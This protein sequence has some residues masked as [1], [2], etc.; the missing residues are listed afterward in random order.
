MDSP[1]P[2]TRLPRGAI[3]IAAEEAEKQ[4]DEL[5]HHQDVDGEGARAATKKPR[6]TEPTPMAKYALATGLLLRC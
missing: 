2:R 5:A 1:L 4:A 3:S 6:R